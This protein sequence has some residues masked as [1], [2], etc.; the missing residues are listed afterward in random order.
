MMSVLLCSEFFMPGMVDTHI[1]AS[2]YTYL[3]TH[4]D[5]PLL[6]WLNKYTY[7]VESRYEDLDFAKDVYAKVVVSRN[8]AMGSKEGRINHYG[9]CI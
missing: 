5:L 2:Q 8:S 6:D 4:L 9:M 1:H 7:P 3:G